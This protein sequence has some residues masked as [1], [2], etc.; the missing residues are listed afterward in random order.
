ML[1]SKISS[2]AVDHITCTE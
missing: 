2:Q 1:V